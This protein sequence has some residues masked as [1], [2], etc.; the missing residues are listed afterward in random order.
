VQHLELLKQL[1]LVELM[2]LLLVLMV[3]VQHL[4]GTYLL[5]NGESFKRQVVCGFGVENG[6]DITILLLIGLPIK[7]KIEDQ[8]I[9]HQM[10]LFSG[11]TGAA[12]LAPVLG[13]LAGA[14]V[15][16]V[17]TAPSVP[18]SSVTT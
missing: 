1:L 3:L 9:M 16:P 13:V 18:A 10:L 15:R 7:Q 8:N 14:V 12:V 17:R 4:L 6:V 11:V 2:S 5:L